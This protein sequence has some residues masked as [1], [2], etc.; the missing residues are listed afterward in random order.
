MARVGAGGA[1]GGPTPR[2]ALSAADGRSTAR[3]EGGAATWCAT[4]CRRRL[5]SSRPGIREAVASSAIR[6]WSPQGWSD[7][8]LT[9][10]QR[11]GNA[12]WQSSLVVA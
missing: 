2:E 3:S 4:V 9:W 10:A 5:V 11:G 1:T 7:G 8:A 12:P 6:S